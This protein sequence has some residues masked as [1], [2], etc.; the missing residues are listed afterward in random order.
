MLQELR[1]LEYTQLSRDDINDSIPLV[2]Q[3]GDRLPHLSL[4]QCRQLL[5]A[6]IAHDRDIDTHQNVRHWVMV[7]LMTGMR[8]GEACQLTGNDCDVK[9]NVLV[10][11]SVTAKTRRTR[12][13]DCGVSLYLTIMVQKWAKLGARPILGTTPLAIRQMLRTLHRWGA[14]K[15]CN[16]HTLRRTTGTILANSMILGGVLYR[17]AGQMG[18]SEAICQRR[19]AGQMRVDS[20]AETMEEAIGLPRLDER[21][22]YAGELPA[23]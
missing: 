5:D 16:P 22:V 7:L 20:Q 4:E 14:P 23:I 12:D 19:Y 9:R 13:I 2:D 1:R 11:R 8:V 3:S 21:V 6:C 15:R 10:V 18:H 17:T